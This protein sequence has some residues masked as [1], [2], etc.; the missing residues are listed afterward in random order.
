MSKEFG[1]RLKLLLEE[2]SMMVDDL[3]F[4]IFNKRTLDARTG[5]K[6]SYGRGQVYKYLQGHVLP[7]RPRY[8]AILKGLNLK[9]ADLPLPNAYKRD[10]L[11]A[12]NNS[13]TMRELIEALDRLTIAVNKLA[14]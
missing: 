5:K 10:A 4:L 9:P 6:I 7:S 13:A 14:N 8:Y 11:S 3:A 1:N 2:R 12:P